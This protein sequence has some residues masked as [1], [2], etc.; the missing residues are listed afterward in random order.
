MTSHPSRQRLA[1]LFL[2]I[3]VEFA[4]LW[5]ENAALKKQLE[6]RGI[7]PITSVQS[8]TLPFVANLP[9]IPV[10]APSAQEKSRNRM[11]VEKKPGDFA[12]FIK[13]GASKL[14]SAIRD[15][16]IE[17]VVTQQF[18]AHVDGVW[19]VTTC[20]WSSRF[21][22]SASADRTAC[23]FDFETRNL[24]CRY[25]G[26]RGSVNSIKFHPTQGLICTGSGDRTCHIWQ[27]PTA[28]ASAAA[29]TTTGGT[30]AQMV[31]SQS[32]DSNDTESWTPLIAS[33][34]SITPIPTVVMSPTAAANVDPVVIKTSLLTLNGEQGHTDVVS[35]CVWK[36][37]GSAIASCSNDGT[38]K[39]WNVT[40]QPGTVEQSLVVGAKVAVT[41]VAFHPRNP[42]VLCCTSS[43]GALRL[44]D[45]STG[46]VPT[47]VVMAHSECARSAVFAADGNV[48]V[49]GGDDRMVKI[50]DARLLKAP[51]FAIHSAASI[52]RVAVG[53]S[54]HRIVAACDDRHSRVYDV[55]GNYPVCLR[56]TSSGV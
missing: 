44:W 3:E 2:A 14:V 15:K 37:D 21:V 41:S 26:H 7:A 19:D 18:S 30:N 36:V 51:T 40:G 31:R 46:T 35:W 29:A 43:D 9:T 45:L 50:W 53:P 42:H 1:E 5:E 25:V 32:F 39:V 38:V 49:T 11:S 20:P 22:G 8:P 10:V 16:K 56:S 48:I 4:S 34:A 54:G 27:L 23:V 55:Q 52:N 24:I 33:K 12:A 28:T 13:G 47:S 6:D 17:W